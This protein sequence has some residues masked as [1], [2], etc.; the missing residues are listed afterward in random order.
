MRKQIIKN[1]LF[2]AVISTF[3]LACMILLMLPK[4]RAWLLEN[5]HIDA[6][7]N[8]IY[9]I[10]QGYG[11]DLVSLNNLSRIYQ[12]S[13]ETV[14]QVTFRPGDQVYYTFV[15]RIL[16]SEYNANNKN[17]HASLVIRGEARDTATSTSGDYLDFLHDCTILEDS[18]L[19]AVLKRGQSTNEGSTVIYYDIVKYHN[20][21]GSY[22]MAT[23]GEVTA[24]SSETTGATMNNEE[25][26]SLCPNKT[27]A[28]ISADFN[29]TIPIVPISNDLIV[30][31]EGN[32]YIFFMVY[33]PITYID[34]GV[35]Q[36]N[37]MDSTLTINGSS[38]LGIN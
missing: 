20:N 4:T 29:V 27:V 1:V 38:I 21:N 15:F 12:S 18:C 30:N 34:T 3:F 31:E 11:D 32:D 19:F 6:E 24:F 2:L 10:N 5:R 35:N 26:A 17:Y 28:S 23:D 33:V 16:A 37:Q 25:V 8:L 14:T 13:D 9:A 36:N 22:E 7:S